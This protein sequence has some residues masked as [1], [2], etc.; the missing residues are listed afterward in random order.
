MSLCTFTPNIL[1][2]DGGGFAAVRSYTYNSYAL[3]RLIITSSYEPRPK[4]LLSVSE[5]YAFVLSYYDMSTIDV[6]SL[7]CTVLGRYTSSL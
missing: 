6:C 5:F 3:S 4:P 1:K 7:L 2:C